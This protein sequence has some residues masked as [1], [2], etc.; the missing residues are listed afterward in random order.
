MALK[1]KKR[2]AT[3]IVAIA[4]V[5]TLAITA[6]ASNTGFGFNNVNVNTS[7]STGNVTKSDSL[8]Y[9]VVN[10][11]G[12][13]F[14]SSDRAI[15]RVT[16]TSGNN[17]TSAVTYSSASGKQNMYFNIGFTG[18]QGQNYRLKMTNSGSIGGLNA[19]GI[20]AP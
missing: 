14:V 16:D 13:N 10:V 12:G 6:A 7:V 4:A 5:S 17:R 9:A 20:W 18:N 11:Q 19:N 15:F 3:A 2:I 1:A 8:Q